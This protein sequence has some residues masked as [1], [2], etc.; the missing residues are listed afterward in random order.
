MSSVVKRTAAFVAMRDWIETEAHEKGESY[1]KTIAVNEK[2]ICELEEKLK[3]E[4]AKRL[5]VP[6]LRPAFGGQAGNAAT[7]APRTLEDLGNELL[8]RVSKQHGADVSHGVVL[9][10]GSGS[11]LHVK[12]RAAGTPFAPKPPAND[13]KSWTKED[14]TKLI[15]LYR[16]GLKL[17]ELAAVFERY[18]DA[19]VLR[20]QL[21]NHANKPTARVPAFPNESWYAE[22]AR[23]LFQL[24]RIW[25]TRQR[26]DLLRSGRERFLQGR[27]A[28][29]RRIRCEGAPVK[30]ALI[31]VAWLF[32]A[33]FV[34]GLVLPG[35]ISSTSDIG[36]VLGVVVFIGFMFG[37]AALAARLFII[38]RGKW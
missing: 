5:Y 10:N 15:R 2:H 21:L 32:L 33:A 25:P 14:E 22:K 19:I 31:I 27:A 1:R 26:F 37:S 20:L 8:D 36:V 7:P 30:L 34:F 13:G 6:A 16:F 11:I 29:R 23:H 28:Y 17:K 4:Q 3:A 9:G 35:L 18:E 12:P 38:Y 24:G